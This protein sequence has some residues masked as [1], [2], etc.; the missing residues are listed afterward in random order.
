M[1]IVGNLKMLGQVFSLLFYLQSLLIRSCVNHQICHVKIRGKYHRRSE[2][3]YLA[4]AGN[5]CRLE[6]R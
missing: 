6:K 4:V 3:L 1:A 2:D 5:T